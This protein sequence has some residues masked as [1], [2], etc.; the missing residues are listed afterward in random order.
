MWRGAL[1]GAVT[2]W[3]WMAVSESHLS[4]PRL[5][6]LHLLGLSQGLAIGATVGGIFALYT[7]R[8]ARWG[9]FLHPTLSLFL[10]GPD[11]APAFRPISPPLPGLR[12]RFLAFF[13]II[14]SFIPLVEYA[15]S[16]LMVWRKG[17]LY[18][19]AWTH[20]DQFYGVHALP[21]AFRAVVVVLLG[22][23]LGLQIGFYLGGSLGAV[24]G[25][26][27]GPLAA[28]ARAL[29]LGWV[30]SLRPDEAKFALGL[31]VIG[32][33][34]LLVGTW[35]L[36]S[37]PSGDG[38]VSLGLLPAAVQRAAV[39]ADGKTMLIVDANGDVTLWQRIPDG[40]NG[41]P[42]YRRSRRMAQGVRLAGFG[43]REKSVYVAQE[44]FVRL[45]QT[46][47]RKTKPAEA[48]FAIR[49]ALHVAPNRE[50]QE[51][52]VQV[53]AN[54]TLE[55]W[56]TRNSRMLNR[57][58]I[59]DANVQ[60]LAWS[61]SGARVLM[62]M[63]NGKVRLIDL[64]PSVRERLL[65]AARG[66]VHA[67]A[68]TPDGSLA[69]SAGADWTIH[70]WETSTATPA[71]QLIGHRGAVHD[72]AVSS[73]KTRLLSGAADRT[74]RLWDLEQRRLLATFHGH[75][76][77]VLSV[78]SLPDGFAV[79]GGADRTVRFWRLP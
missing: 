74:M 65:P 47:G 48:T 79:S 25:W 6:W 23:T 38:S 4:W 5:G 14:L 2:A 19:A 28:W 18:V 9:I 60:R 7:G 30:R 39:S 26:I 10:P 55:I 36:L 34:G 54:R 17:G 15:Y 43:P 37:T 70:L 71:G 52:L 56:D 22:A 77:I 40:P 53:A 57:F 29:P 61:S 21:A 24:T 44:N 51:L 69:L 63:T 66:P 13:L 67:V 73:D 27:L 59:G 72:L 42:L 58:A 68:F 32:L 75:T 50:R 64:A 46:E 76:N 11:L 1:F 62:G 31:P 12:E 49:Q 8:A 78:A 33:S 45:L 16:R 41:N 3:M 35:L 20:V